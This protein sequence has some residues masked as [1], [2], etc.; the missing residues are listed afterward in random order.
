MATTCCIS[1]TR[2]TFPHDDLI[3]DL[4]VNKTTVFI[5]ICPSDLGWPATGKRTLLA[6]LCSEKL[7]WVGPRDV[8]SVRH[9]LGSCNCDFIAEVLSR[10]MRCDALRC[11]ASSTCCV[12]EC[13]ARPTEENTS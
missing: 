8:Q 4:G 6:S 13:D 9:G 10:G 12:C 5:K 2:P 7:V 3:N 1:R 11:D